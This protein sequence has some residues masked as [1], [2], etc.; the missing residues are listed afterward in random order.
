MTRSST[1]RGLVLAFI[2]GTCLLPSI[3]QAVNIILGT[4]NDTSYL[5]LQ[6]TN[7]GVRTYEIQYTYNSGSPQDGYF[8]LDTVL[9]S[10]SSLHASVGLP[11]NRFLSSMT[12][13][14]VTEQYDGTNFWAQWVS[15]GGTGYLNPDYTFNPGIPT[16]GSW[17]LG[18]GLSSRF[19]AP[20]SWDAL[21]FSDGI[22]FP[23]VEPV[24]EPSSWLM[25]S[26][27]VLLIFKRRRNG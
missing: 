20:G 3:S 24:P 26:A 8:L 11:G 13:N 16:P 7:L 14:S 21:Y 4:G 25:G 2:A 10:D 12:Y 19:I 22:A 18:Y 17:A 27:A 15:G 1:G 9:G 5:V 23:T 6:S